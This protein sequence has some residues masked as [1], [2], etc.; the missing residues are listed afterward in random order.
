MGVHT[1]KGR[2]TDERTLVEQNPMVSSSPHGKLAVL[3]RPP[4]YTRYRQRRVPLCVLSRGQQSPRDPTTAWLTR[5]AANSKL[6]SHCRAIPRSPITSSPRNTKARFSSAVYSSRTFSLPR[7]ARFS[8]EFTCGSS[9]CQANVCVC[10]WTQL[11]SAV[12]I[13]VHA[14]E[15]CCSTDT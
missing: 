1:S 5:G 8:C 13:H 7:P 3:S 4:Y 12:V 14:H 11:M 2:K 15:R 9:T 6:C 10:V